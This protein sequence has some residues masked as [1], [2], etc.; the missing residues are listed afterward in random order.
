M[1]SENKPRTADGYVE[2]I[3][4]ACEQAL[5]TLLGA[6]GTLGDDLRLIGGLAPRYLTPAKP[7]EVPAHAGTTDVDIVLDLA[8]IIDG[9]NYDSLATQLAE[10][11][12]KRHVSAGKSSSWQWR[13]EIG[14]IPVLVEFLSDG[15]SETR[16]KQIPLA[17]EE[18]S[19]MAIPHAGIVRDWFITHE[20]TA[21]PLGGGLLTRNVHVADVPSFV[22]LKALALNNRYAP[23]DA[24]DLIHVLQYAGTIDGIAG[25][26]VERKLSGLHDAAIEAGLQALRFSFVHPTRPDQSHIC[27]GPVKYASFHVAASDKDALMEAQRYAAGLVRRLLAAYELQLKEAKRSARR[28]VQL[29]QT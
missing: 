6:F 1:G 15:G 12:F 14:A 22:I 28:V 16:P 26:F 7:P 17:G 29:D 27:D 25:M 10:R 3:T 9:Q 4:N 11:G 8:V 24:A 2:E 13:L 21:Q 18:V 23:K 19:T 5:I 20:L